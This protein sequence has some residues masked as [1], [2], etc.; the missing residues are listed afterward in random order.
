VDDVQVD[1]QHSGTYCVEPSTSVW[2]ARPT[3]ED[4]T[5]ALRR[6]GSSRTIA[7]P[8]GAARIEWPGD[9]PIEDASQF[10]IAA[11]G[12]ARATVIFHAMSSAPASAPARV[13]EGI[14]LGCRDQFES[15]LR[16][17][18]R[19][20]VGPALWM[21]TDHGR[22]PAY[23]PG[24]PI[25]LTITADVDGYLYCVAA[26]DDGGATPIFPAGAVDG[27]QLRG[28]EPLSIPGRRQPAGMTAAPGLAQIRCWLADRDISAELPHALLGA[29]ATRLPDQVANELDAIFARVAGP[30][31]AVDVLT[32][33]ME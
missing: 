2:I 30:R 19:S 13:A 24:A 3:G 6:K 28:S 22:R 5:Y 17:I 23:R 20:S 27:A 9:V 4:T 16:R 21:T 14:I 7:W 31:V 29:P 10:E 33:R 15:E 26:R 12:A 8:S 18:S 32:V 1:P 11:D 25:A